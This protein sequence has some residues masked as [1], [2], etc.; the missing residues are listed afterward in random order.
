[1]D[2]VDGWETVGNSLGRAPLGTVGNR[3]GRAPLGG[4]ET[5]AWTSWTH[6][7]LWEI[8]WEL[9]WEPWE[10]RLGRAPAGRERDGSVDIV[11]A[12]E[13]AWGE[14]ILRSRAVGKGFQETN[15]INAIVPKNCPPKIF[16]VVC[17]RFGRWDMHSFVG[18]EEI[19]ELLARIFQDKFHQRDCPEKLV[20]KTSQ[21]V[22]NRWAKGPAGH[23]WEKSSLLEGFSFCTAFC[24]SMLGFRPLCSEAS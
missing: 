10:N 5:E 15:S 12:W 9:R 22:S 11:D 23:A 19:T 18:R 1:M 16:Q 13:I 4:S 21:T 8:A 3:L 7:K 24:P 17:K 20:P 2:I 14:E 6:G